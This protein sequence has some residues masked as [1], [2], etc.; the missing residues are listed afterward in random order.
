MEFAIGGEAH[1]DQLAGQVSLIVKV[2]RQN[3]NT[4]VGTFQMMV[5]TAASD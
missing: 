4:D 5:K 1:E 3:V 2:R